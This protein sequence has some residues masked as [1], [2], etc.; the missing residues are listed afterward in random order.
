MLEQEIYVIKP[1]VTEEDIL[2]HCFTEE[3]EKAK[4]ISLYIIYRGIKFNREEAG[5]KPYKQ[6]CIEKGLS[7]ELQFIV[8]KPLMG[9]PEFSWVSISFPVQFLMRWS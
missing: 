6:H 7:P 1:G 9:I 5:T 2:K 8:T 4:K 3:D